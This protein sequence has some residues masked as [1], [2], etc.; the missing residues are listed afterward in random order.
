MRIRVVPVPGLDS[1]IINVAV[2]VAD[3]DPVGSEPFWLDPDL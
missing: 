1:L 2:S 3:P